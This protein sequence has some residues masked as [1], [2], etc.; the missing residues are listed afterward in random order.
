MPQA[1]LPA[2]HFSRLHDYT[3]TKK[4]NF[5]N[6]KQYS[7]TACGRFL[8]ETM[9]DVHKN[10]LRRMRENGKSYSQI[11][12]AMG[13]SE[14]TVKSCCRRMGV[15]ILIP[16]AACPQCGK[17]L[18]PS[19]RGQRRRFC[20]DSCRYAWDYAHR[21]LD[22]RNAVSGKCKACGKVFFS[23]PSSHRKYCSHGCYIAD[24]YGREAYRHDAG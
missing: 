8:E 14:N 15:Q 11:A 9:L 5:K 2:A 20:S 19:A 24:R 13:L 22:A 6:A 18:L 23:Y 4:Q 3:T 17:A 7:I 1:F 12:A 21:I 10:M 16:K